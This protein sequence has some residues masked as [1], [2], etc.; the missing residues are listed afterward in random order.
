MFFRL[1]Q[2]VHKETTERKREG[3]KETYSIDRH[4]ERV[5]VREQ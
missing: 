5:R 3:K 1:A 2:S 4:V